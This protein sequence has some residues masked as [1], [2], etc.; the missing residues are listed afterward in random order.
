MAAVQEGCSAVSASR[1]TQSRICSS[2]STSGPGEISPPSNAARAGWP[3]M[4]AGHADRLDPLAA[5]LVGG[6]VVEPQR[7]VRARVRAGDPAGAA[8]VGV[9]RADVHLVAVA[10]RGRRA[11]VAHRDGQEVEHQVRVVDVVVAA[12]EAT[13]LEVV[14]R[15]G[16]AARKSHCA[17]IPGAAPFG[18][19]RLHRHRL[20]ARVLDV[21]LQVILEVLA[22]ARAGRATTAMPSAAQFAGVA[23]ARQLQQ[24]RR[25]DR[26][27]AEDDLAAPTRRTGRRHA[28]TR[29]RPRA[30]P[31]SHPGD[32]GARAD[33]EVGP[34]HHGLQVR[35]ATA[36]SR[37]PRWTL[38]SNRAKPSCR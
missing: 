11:V 33:V 13:G 12:D 32:Q 31:R 37:R 4:L 8:G 15:A 2:D 10:G 7:R 14:G 29:R 34:R 16:A 6:Q 1:A 18:Q 30:C 5:V 23:H 35:A 17:P 21:D 19:V 3:R 26:P 9:H 24:L 38:R 20:R 36:D 28:S 25:V 22:D 27:A